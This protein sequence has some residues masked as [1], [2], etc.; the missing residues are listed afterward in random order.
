[1]RDS[2][3]LDAL[4]GLKVA[5]ASSCDLQYFVNHIRSM[6]A[7]SDVSYNFETG[8]SDDASIEILLPDTKL[9]DADIIVASIAE[10]SKKLIYP[11]MNGRTDSDVEAIFKR[12]EAALRSVLEYLQSSNAKSCFIFKYPV[13]L[14]KIDINDRPWAEGSI[15]YWLNKLDQLYISMMAEGN[16]DKVDILDL[17]AALAPV[18]LGERYFR[19]EFWGGHPEGQGA[20]ILGDEF[21]ERVISRL[22]HQQKIKAIALDLDHTLWD[23]VFLESEVPPKIFGNRAAALMHH[24]KK[25]IPICVVS[26]NNPEDIDRISKIIKEAAPGL[27]RA[28]VGYY[29]S[30]QPKSDSIRTMASTMGIGLNTI[31]FFDDNEFERGEVAFAI[32]EVRVYKEV[33]IETSL[34][35]GEFSFVRISKDAARRV[36]SYRENVERAVFEE[37][38][39]TTDLA[40]YLVSLGFKI[41]F[42]KASSGDLDRV[43]ELV[44][45]TNQQNLLL[46]RTARSVIS[47]YIDEGRVV[48]ISLCDK[49]GDYGTIG[50]IVYDIEGP[51]VTLVELAI[52]CRAL[53]KGVEECIITFIDRFFGDGAIV[54]FPVQRTYRNESFFNKMVESGFSFDEQQSRM[55]MNLTG[56]RNYPSWFEVEI[57]L[58]HAEL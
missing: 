39:A 25:G 2:A 53:G 5:V 9:K 8:S 17:N 52:S 12:V 33:E 15:S 10:T 6:K 24:V 46:S 27:A 22:D 26:K 49:F 36:Q 56:G 45:R 40:G 47:R 20:A 44:Q 50:A 51:S 14:S 13:D 1:M 48:L 31:A 7:F 57:L 19:N 11:L 16:Y 41:S 42:V 4:S 29:V 54:Q 35:Y 34:R 43:D 18:G 37:S 30:W 21:V 28:I 38:A 55:S 58:G 23:G 32:P 3:K